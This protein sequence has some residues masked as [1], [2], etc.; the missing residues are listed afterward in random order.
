MA[1]IS[2]KTSK[3]F[4]YGKLKKNNLSKIIYSY[5]LGN[6]ILKHDNYIVMYCSL[7]KLF[8]KQHKNGNFNRMDIVVRYLAIEQYYGKNNS[9]YELYTKMQQKRAQYTGPRK[10]KNKNIQRKSH[11]LSKFKELITDIENNGYN[12][13]EKININHKLKLRDGSHRIACALYFG[14]KYVPIKFSK[15]SGAADYGID[16][17]RSNGFLESE[18]ELINQKYSEIVT[19]ILK[20]E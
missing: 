19:E 6:I 3:L 17:F 11:D 16:W 1:T 8:N 13:L 20:N 12:V 10:V 7:D 9:G 18:I 2:N 15:S 4:K 14:V 5:K